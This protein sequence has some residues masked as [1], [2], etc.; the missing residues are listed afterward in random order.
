MSR[1]Q[2]SVFLNTLVTNLTLIAYRLQ[3]KS[4]ERAISNH[5]FN[6]G[7]IGHCMEKGLGT[8]HENQFRP[9]WLI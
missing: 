8:A 2:F 4:R 6:W 3:I 5:S 9:T 7:R 1:V